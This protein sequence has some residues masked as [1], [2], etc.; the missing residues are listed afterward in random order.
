MLEDHPILS[1]VISTVIAIPFAVT[2]AVM[3]LGGTI[4]ITIP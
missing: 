1:L 2:V 3:L 4:R